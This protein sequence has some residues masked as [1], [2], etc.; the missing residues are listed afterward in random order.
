MNTTKLLSLAS[1]LIIISSA[2]AQAPEPKPGSA[3][4]RDSQGQVIRDGFGGC[5]VSGFYTPASW[6]WRHACAARDAQW[7]RGRHL[8]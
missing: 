1:A 7:R 3:Y 6:P 2:L 4:W 5:V 8:Q